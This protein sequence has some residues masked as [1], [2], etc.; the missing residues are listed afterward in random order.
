V[1][2]GPFAHGASYDLTSATAQALGMTVTS[3]LGAVRVG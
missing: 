3:R 1:D 2:R